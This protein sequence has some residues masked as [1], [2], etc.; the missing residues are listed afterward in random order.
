MFILCR[1]SFALNNIIVF[2]DY[3]FIDKDSSIIVEETIINEATQ[4][5]TILNAEVLV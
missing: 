3:N 2:M 1:D 5:T 4:T